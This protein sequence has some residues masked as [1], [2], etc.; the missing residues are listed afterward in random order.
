ML[1]GLDLVCQRAHSASMETFH[2]YVLNSCWNLADYSWTYIYVLQI[3]V[4]HRF[5]LAQVDR[6]PKAHVSYQ[7]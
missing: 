6:F 5:I 4:F 3:Q 2:S 1:M 7:I